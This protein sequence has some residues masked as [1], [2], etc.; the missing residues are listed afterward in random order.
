MASG[1][2]FVGDSDLKRNIYLRTGKENYGLP[3]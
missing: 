1:T 3:V 2:Y